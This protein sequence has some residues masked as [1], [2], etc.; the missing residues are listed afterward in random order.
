M[1]RNKYIAQSIVHAITSANG[2]HKNTRTLLAPILALFAAFFSFYQLSLR[3]IRPA[4]FATSKI[5]PGY[6][7]HSFFR[8]DLLTSYVEYM[9]THSRSM[10]VRICNFLGASGSSIGGRIFGF[11]PSHHIDWDLKPT[12]YFYPER[13]IADGALTSEATKSQVADEF[14]GKIILSHAQADEFFSSLETDTKLLAEHN[15]VDYS[16]FLVRIKAPRQEAT[17]PNTSAAAVSVVPTDPL[18]VPLGPPSLRTG[19]VSPDGKHIFRAANFDF[20]WVK[21]KIQLI[22]MTSLIMA[23]RLFI[24]KKG[25]MSITTTPDEYRERFLYMCRG[26]VE[27]KED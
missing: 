24:S 17:D 9:V 15:V 25:P 19:V 4:N 7:E 8:D 21:H 20:F 5:C 13:D 12:S 16:L 27:I 1:E 3:K 23:Y 10:L 22:V 2:F 26:I 11:A 6:S 14:H 18:S